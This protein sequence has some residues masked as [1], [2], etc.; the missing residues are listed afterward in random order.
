MTPRISVFGLEERIAY[1]DREYPSS[2]EILDAVSRRGGISR[3]MTLSSKRFTGALSATV[4]T[5]FPS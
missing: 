1:A 4:A 2:R 5:T 3:F